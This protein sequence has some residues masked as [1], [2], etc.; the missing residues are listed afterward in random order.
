VGAGGPG[1]PGQRGLAGGELTVQG[2][3]QGAGQ[4]AVP[5]LRS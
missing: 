4:E 1:R 5:E 3:A 2:R